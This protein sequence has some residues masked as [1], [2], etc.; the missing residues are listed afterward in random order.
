MFIAYIYTDAIISPQ[1]LQRRRGSFTAWTMW[2]WP[3]RDAAIGHLLVLV[4]V[5]SWLCLTGFKVLEYLSE[6]TATK[7]I[8][9]RK[10]YLPPFTICPAL[11]TTSVSEGNDP[12]RE[13]DTLIKL[14]RDLAL[15]PEDIIWGLEASKDNPSEY[16]SCESNGCMEFKMSVDLDYGG[17]CVT[18]KAENKNYFD[19]SLLPN[20]LYEYEGSENPLTYDIIFHGHVDFFADRYME[21]VTY[22]M[23]TAQRG[24]S[25]TITTDRQIRANLRRDPCVEDPTYSKRL[26]ERQCYLDRLNCS[27]YDDNEDNK[28]RCMASDATWY[29]EARPFKTFFNGDDGLNACDCPKPCV[30][31]SITVAIQPD[32]FIIDDNNTHVQLNSATTMKVLHTY[33]RYTLSDLAADIGGFLG[34][35]LGWSI[36]SVCQLLPKPAKW[37][38]RQCGGAQDPPPSARERRGQERSWVPTGLVSPYEGH[39][40]DTVIRISSRQDRLKY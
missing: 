27:M 31:D 7:T 22:F 39:R 18:S 40:G 10:H 4:L 17:A 11:R 34:L 36:L 19:I 26:C 33:V 30:T 14:F 9:E 38:C 32:F 21:D 3:G 12:D 29:E 25:M 24:M 15:N 35:F 23:S 28:P 20:P 5:A 37:A 1:I 8:W 13:N 6:P 2:S 16:L